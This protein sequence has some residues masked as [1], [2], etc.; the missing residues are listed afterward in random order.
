MG[1]L[2]G[3]ATAIS[4]A[5]QIPETKAVVAFD[6]FMFPLGTDKINLHKDLKCLIITTQLFDMETRMMRG[7]GDYSNDAC[8]RKFAESHSDKVKCNMLK[9][10]TSF[11]FS[12]KQIIDPILFWGA[13]LKRLPD[14]LYPELG[15]LPAQLSMQF[16]SEHNLCLKPKL[17]A[18]L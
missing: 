10:L 14:P 18:D 13:T 6:P 17:Q 9:N 8:V 11:V 12:D 5:S 3:G 15:L 4:A 1:S 7:A 16:F 2:L